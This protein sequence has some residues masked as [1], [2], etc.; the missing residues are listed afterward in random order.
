MRSRRWRVGCLV[1]AWIACA[2]P[3][4][5]GRADAPAEGQGVVVVSVP[6]YE[7]TTHAYGTGSLSMVTVN[8]MDFQPPTMGSTPQ[9]TEWN[10]NADGYLWQTNGIGRPWF[11]NLSLPSGAIVERVELNACD[12]SVDVE[13]V[14]GMVSRSV[15][16]GVLVDVVPVTTTGGTQAPGC[17]LFPV[18][19]GSPVVIDNLGTDYMLKL[20]LQNDFF[21]QAPVASMRV[22]YRLQVSPA[23]ATAT[24]A[25]VPVGHPLHRFVEALAAAG[26]TGGCTATA[27][28]PDAP[29]T[30]GQMA[31]FLSVALGLHWPN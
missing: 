15:P 10:T 18:T 7:R 16:G 29:L 25:D 19:P 24:F 14:F 21:A 9:D 8:I 6:E 30:R 13:I 2:G 22:F 28:C 1:L 31:V 4:F 20:I 3:G 11:A 27:Y 12:T 5:A 26:I 17:A 23:P